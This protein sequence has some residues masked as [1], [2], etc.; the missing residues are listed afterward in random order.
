ML[1]LNEFKFQVQTGT[2][3]NKNLPNRVKKSSNQ[4]TIINKRKPK[5]FKLRTEIPMI[6]L[7]TYKPQKRKAKEKPIILLLHRSE[8]KSINDK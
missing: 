5:K 6:C 3:S 7:S 4:K 1:Q 8:L 2:K